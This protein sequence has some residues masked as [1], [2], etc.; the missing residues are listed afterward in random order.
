M[1]DKELYQQI[2]GIQKPWFVESVKLDKEREEIR[3]ARSV[4]RRCPATTAD[5]G[6]GGTWTPASTRRSLRRTSR[7]V[8]VKSTEFGRSRFHGLNEGR[9]LRLC[10]NV[11]R[12]TG[13]RKLRKRP[14]RVVWIFRGE[15]SMAL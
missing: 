9:S 6:L 13:L 8:P 12:S 7:E 5:N 1:H 2:L 10:S 11:W 14:S 4:R 15:R 3:V